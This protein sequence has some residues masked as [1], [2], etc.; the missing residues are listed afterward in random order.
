MKNTRHST[1]LE[2]GIT[3]I[4]EQALHAHRIAIGVNV[5]AGGIHEPADKA[6]LA[7]LLEHVLFRGTTSLPGPKLRATIEHLGGHINGQTF[8]DRTAYTGTVILE[9]L[10]DTVSLLADMVMNPTLLEDDIDL[11]KQIV[12]DENCRGCFGCTMNESF[13]EA[14]YPEQ[15][16]S[17]PVIGYE[18][19]VNALTRADLVAFHRAYYTGRNTTVAVC[20]N[21]AHDDIVALVREAFSGMPTGTESVWPALDYHGGDMQLATSSEESNLWIG[22]DFTD[23]SDDEKRAAYIFSDILGGHGQSRLMQELR[24]K[25]GL[26]YHVSTEVETYVRRDALR[27]YLHGPSAKFREICDLASEVVRDSAANLSEDEMRKALRR[28]H[29]NVTMSLDALEA[30]VEDMITD[31]SDIGRISDPEERHQG[32]MAL[33]AKDVTDA[34]TK[35][36]LQPPTIVMSAPVRN[37]PKIS[38]LREKLSPNYN[39]GGLLQMFKRAG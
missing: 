16:M 13:F 38:E 20:G 22:Y 12:D 39:A 5:M 36:L 14:A 18:D 19:T 15:H 23:L 3:V 8:Q 32:Y 34:G 6:G 29:I 31:V 9:N 24:E 33:T 26:V 10:P 27:I 4:S 7:H 25:R 11:E 35:L 2:N 17:Q 28:H 37:A 21:I 1:I 30:R